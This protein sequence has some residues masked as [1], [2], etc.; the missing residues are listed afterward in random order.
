M[1]IGATIEPLIEGEIRTVLRFGRSALKT[2]RYT[3]W[4]FRFPSPSADFLSE[5]AAEPLQNL[6]IKEE[7]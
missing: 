4:G 2:N 1:R 5:N 3:R 6:S 7:E